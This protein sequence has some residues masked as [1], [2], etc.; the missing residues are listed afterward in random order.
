MR[1]PQ[2][3]SIPS[4]FTLVELL[5][6]IGIIALLI[7][8]LL[9]S[10][11]GARRRAE[12]IA[13]LSNLR[14]IGQ[15]AVMYA[16]VNKGFLPQPVKVGAND[17]FYRFSEPQAA[18]LSNLLKGST[19]IFYCPSNHLNPPAGQDP[20]EM[21]DFYPPDH[22]KPWIG[23][24]I[25][26]GRISYWWVA[27]PNEPDY[28]GPPVAP[29]A[30]PGG[31]GTIGGFAP[32]GP[33]WRDVNMNGSIRD[34]YMRRLGDKNVAN[35]VIC[36]DQSGQLTGGQGWIFIHGKEAHLDKSASPSE[37]KKL[38]QSWKNNLYGDGHAES[39][40]PDEVEWRWGPGAPACW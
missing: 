4:G 19:N 23:A 13:C 40:R 37:K 20:I 31:G 14:S 10:L 9:P 35:I 21:S 17:S 11:A 5:V 39:K 22:G 7:S 32:S 2:R 24:P 16:N 38:Y 6:V 36:T 34:E 18:L 28:Q 12:S 15:A 25:K 30:D 8:I 1:K 3:S 29:M 33:R 27:D 26:S